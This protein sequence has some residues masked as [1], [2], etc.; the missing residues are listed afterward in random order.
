M[1]RDPLPRGGRA[2]RDRRVAHQLA[3]DGVLSILAVVV[4]L[5][6]IA[7]VCGPAQRPGR[8]GLEEGDR[9]AEDDAHALNPGAGRRSR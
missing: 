7:W 3:M 1:G 6:I 5:L 9:A 4:G 8:P 2:G